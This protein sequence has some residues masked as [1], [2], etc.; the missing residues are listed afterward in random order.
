MSSVDTEMFLVLVEQGVSQSADDPFPVLLADPKD[1]EGFQP[2]TTR[3]R[4]TVRMGVCCFFVTFH[5]S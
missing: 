4:W 5:M 1:S 3:T 2:S